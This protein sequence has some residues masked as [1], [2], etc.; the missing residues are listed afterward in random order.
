MLRRR[1]IAGTSLVG[2]GALVAVLALLKTSSAS[3]GDHFA[4][5]HDGLKIHYETE[6]DGVP[7]VLIAGGPGT[8]AD[9]LKFTHRLLRGCA[10]LVFVDNRGRGRSDAPKQPS[11]YTLE[12]D[13][14]D[15]EAVR[16]DLGADKII[17]YGHSYG[18]MVAYSYALAHPD[19]TMAV[20]TT[21]GIYGAKVWQERDIDMIKIILER[22]YPKLWARIVE[23]HEHG[24]LTGDPEV[25]K[26]LRDMDFYHYNP[27]APWRLFPQ[28][29]NPGQRINF[30]N[31]DVYLAMVGPDPEWVMG[32][33]LK[34]VELLPQLSKI[35]APAL[36]M[37]GRHDLIT[38][39]LN[40]IEISDA[41][42]H[43]KLVI[44]EQSAHLPFEDEPLR[45][46]NV[47]EDF[48]ADVVKKQ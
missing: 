14:K 46:L 4:V 11:D 31:E 8:S 19:R 41:I 5:S 33:T 21:G 9:A 22:Q 39:V 2:V 18:S 6:G 20:I 13:V 45:F 32:G 40:Q 12:N 24:R 3:P 23:L 36:I 42:P 37:G 10:R 43:A 47:V 35:T 44:F 26:A 28:F 38:P 1:T 27:E 7:M 16:R 25:R 29:P 17:V 48:I 30:H 15:V 34:N